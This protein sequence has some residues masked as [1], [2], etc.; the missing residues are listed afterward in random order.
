VFV[1]HTDEDASGVGLANEKTKEQ[2]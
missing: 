2:K 1:R